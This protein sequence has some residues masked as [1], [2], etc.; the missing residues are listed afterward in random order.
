MANLD[1]ATRMTLCHQLN[2]EDGE[3]SVAKIASETGLTL[4]RCKG[5]ADEYRKAGA[6]HG[7]T[8]TVTG[9]NGT[10][11]TPEEKASFVATLFG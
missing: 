9:A 2:T 5:I 7:V 1:Y 8:V 6:K 10:R 4:Q 3:L 11:K